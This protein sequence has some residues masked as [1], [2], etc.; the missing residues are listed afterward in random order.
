MNSAEESRQERKKRE[1]R[2][3]IVQTA[4]ELFQEQGFYNTTMEQIAEVA[5]VARKTLYNHF[6]VKEAIA[7]SYLR[8]ISNGLAQESFESLQ[9]LPDTK[10][11]LVA[12]L[13]ATYS[14]AEKNPELTRVVLGYRMKY[15]YQKPLAERPKTGTQNIVEAILT[16]GQEN[17]EIRKDFSVEL[18]MM[19]VDLLRGSIT[20]G[21]LHEPDKFDM[22]EAMEKMVDLVL[23]G[24]STDKRQA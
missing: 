3:R 21:W 8:D 7:D 24:A 9:R 6:P 13:T 23:H 18:L 11:R 1:L 12:A 16:Q 22:T 4:V 19:Y 20:W 15:D 5:D 10:S 2:E 14:W 17:G